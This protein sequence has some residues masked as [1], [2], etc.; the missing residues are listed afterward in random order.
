MGC[1]PDVFSRKIYVVNQYGKEDSRSCPRC[2]FDAKNG[3]SSLNVHMKVLL[4]NKKTR[5]F[6]EE[7][8]SWTNKIEQAFGFINSGEAID[9]A[10]KHELSDVHVVLWFKEQNH[11]LI[12]PFQR[13]QPDEPGGTI[14]NHGPE[15]RERI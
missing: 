3:F 12:I 7:P 9:F 4:Q 15:E 8:G 2:V 1:L 11:S 6:L 10:F 13:E 5:L 14:P